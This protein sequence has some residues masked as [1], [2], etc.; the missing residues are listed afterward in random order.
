MS[1]CGSGSGISGGRS[2]SGISGGG[3]ESGLSGGGRG[4]VGEMSGC[5]SGESGNGGESVGV[6]E[7]RMWNEW[8]EWLRAYS[9]QTRGP[10]ATESKSD[11]KPKPCTELSDLPFLIAVLFLASL[12]VYIVVGCCL[13][14]LDCNL[15]VKS[16]YYDFLTN[17]A[18]Q[19]G[20][21]SPVEID[22]T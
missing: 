1:G 9:L 5:G 4:S 2:G 22:H 8:W 14:A 6:A 19:R 20:D 3:S 7:Q 13:L 18:D 10:Q 15:G 12:L 21:V 16:Y 17:H 11:S